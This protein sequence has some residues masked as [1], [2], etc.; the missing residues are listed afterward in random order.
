VRLEPG[1]DVDFPGRALGKVREELFVEKDQ[2]PKVEPF[3]YLRKKQLQ[4]VLE[5]LLQERLKELVVSQC[6][7][8][9]KGDEIGRAHPPSTV[10][11]KKCDP[12]PH[13]PISRF[14]I[15]RASLS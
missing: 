7:P 13:G 9:K 3:R 2:R 15:D 8:L 14:R 4:E 6:L 5:E 1:D 10:E 12:D 11:R